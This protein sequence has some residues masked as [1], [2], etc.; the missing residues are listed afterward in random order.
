M[1]AVVCLVGSPKSET[2]KLV[3][4]L[5]AETPAYTGMGSV[6][7]CWRTLMMVTNQSDFCLPL[8]NHVRRWVSMFALEEAGVE[9]EKERKAQTRHRTQNPKKKEQRKANQEKDQDR[10]GS[11]QTQRKGESTAESAPSS[12]YFLPVLPLLQIHSSHIERHL[13]RSQGAK[14]LELA[15]QLVSS[16]LTSV[17]RSIASTSASLVADSILCL[18]IGRHVCSALTYSL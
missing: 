10:K 14:D 1:A 18:G 13:R 5:A 4:E 8:G 15:G 11:E 17:A 7:K 9:E 2:K 3:V 16:V 6:P 12:L